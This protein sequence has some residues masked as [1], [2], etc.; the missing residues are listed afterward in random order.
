MFRKTDQRSSML[1]KN[2]LGSAALKAVG[3][4]CSLLIVPV[5]LDY[6]SSEVYGIWLTITSILYWFAFFDVGLGNGMRNYLTQAL[7]EGHHEKAR[8]YLSTTL[9]MLSAIALLV[10]LAVVACA[11]L[12]DMSKVF[13]TAA[14]G[15]RELQ[16]AL[17]V[18]TA[19]TLV[20]FVVKNIGLVFVALQK[21]A[22]NDLLAILGSV[23]ALATVYVL[24]LTTEGNLLYV[25]AAFTGIP[26]L[27]YLLAC[28]PIFRHYPFLRP[29]WRSLDL[30][31]GRQI[32][33]KGL[34]FFAIQITSC[35]VIFGSSNLFIIQYAGPSEVTTYNIAYKFFNLLAIAYTIIVSP[36][37]NAYTDAYV[38]GDTAWI[39]KT[40]RTALR[41]WGLTV[42]GGCVMLAASGLFYRLWVGPAVSVPVSLSA[43]VLAYISLFNLNSGVTALL[44][45]LNKIRVQIITSIVIT[46]LY[47]AAV[48]LFG[49]ALGT[50]GIVLAMAAS[51]LAMAAVHLYQCRLLLRGR[52]R[53]LWDK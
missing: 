45:G 19:F 40:F 22:L 36:M 14:L 46:A 34:G 52:A 23:L 33:C 30:S 27:V 53:G 44:N 3:L 16:A 26:V 9:V 31:L 47:L 20:S 28:I 24:T 2:V 15:S 49:H 50:R 18:A 21:Y 5:T 48:L 51:Y 6:L 32:V 8:S 41:M 39:G 29:A 37:W 1:R 17:L 13:N 10:G 43:S 35:L 42:L 11:L 4:C 25:V 38:K 12:L 7:S